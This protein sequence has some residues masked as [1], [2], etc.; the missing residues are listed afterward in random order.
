[1][2]LGSGP[3]CD[4]Q[5][6]G[7]EPTGLLS[8]GQRLTPHEHLRGVGRSTPRGDRTHHVLH[9]RQAPPTR[10]AAAPL[11][12][13]GWIRTSA[14]RINNPVPCQLG[15]VGMVARAGLEPALRT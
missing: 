13:H 8:Y 5:V 10:W 2:K 3:S 15:D 4:V 7:V 1:M 6:A 12:S 9:I 14:I 11:R